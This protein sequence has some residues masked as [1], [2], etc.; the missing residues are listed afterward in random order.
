MGG[1]EGGEGKGEREER[2]KE[3]GRGREKSCNEQKTLTVYTSKH[4]NATIESISSFYVN[5]SGQ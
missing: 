4:H 2:G 1:R 3:S 5:Y